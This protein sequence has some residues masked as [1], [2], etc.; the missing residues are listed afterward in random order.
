VVGTC[1]KDLNDSTNCPL[2]GFEVRPNDARALG[3]LAVCYYMGYDYP[4]AVDTFKKAIGIKP[5]DAVV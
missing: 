4:G 5:N 2:V 1:G 3:E